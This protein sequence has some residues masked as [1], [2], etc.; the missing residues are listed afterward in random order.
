VGWVVGG[1]I[2]NVCFTKRCSFD[3]VAVRVRS[4]CY[5][6]RFF[7]SGP[8]FFFPCSYSPNLIHR[9]I[10]AVV[11]FAHAHRLRMEPDANG[12]VF[13][14]AIP[15]QLAPLHLELQFLRPTSPSR[16]WGDRSGGE[17]RDSSLNCMSCI[18]GGTH[19]ADGALG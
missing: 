10:R 9:W 8:L 18:A 4:G 19:G 17:D 11:L 2:L 6:I 14:S 7:G 16:A 12:S 15:G 1:Q 13:S 5:L 3:P